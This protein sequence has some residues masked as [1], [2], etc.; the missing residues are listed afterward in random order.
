M[1]SEK[2]VQM[3]CAEVLAVLSD[4]IDNELDPAQRAAVEAHLSTCERC[5]QFGGAFGAVVT[6]LRQAQARGSRTG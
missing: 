6:A 3:E 2:V 4:Y 1:P 5:A